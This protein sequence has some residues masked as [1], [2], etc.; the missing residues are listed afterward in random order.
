MQAAIDFPIIGN[1]DIN[2]VQDAQRV[3]KNTSGIMIGRASYGKPWFLG[4]IR[5]FLTTGLHKAAPPLSLQKEIAM[6]HFQSLLTYYGTQQGMLIARKHLSWYSKGIPG[7]HEFR[8]QIFQNAEPASIL[9]HI[10]NFYDRAEQD[11]LADT[12]TSDPTLGR[13]TGDAPGSS[14]NPVASPNTH[15]DTSR[16]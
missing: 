11:L 8:A 2:T 4:Q 7:A 14:D 6:E 10:E 16:P 15:E 9:S 13:I 5:H 12:P 1:G 3:I